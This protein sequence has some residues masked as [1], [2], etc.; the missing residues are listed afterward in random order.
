[1]A[2]LLAAVVAYT[3]SFSVV[4]QGLRGVGASPE[5]AASGLLAL[6][7]VMGLCSIV[8]SWRT[9]MPVSIA[10]S[11]PGAAFLAISGVPEGGFAAAVGA[12]VI[13]GVLLVISGALRPVARLIGKVPRSLAS[14]MLAGILFD[15][16]LAPVRAFAEM[17]WQGALIALTFIAVGLWKRLFAVP[18]TALVTIGL[19]VAAMPADFSFAN[20]LGTQPVFVMPEFRFSAM[21]GIAVPLFIITMA[22]QNVPGFAILK[23]NGYEPA[24]APIF[25]ATG[26]AT[27]VSAP[28]GA[29]VF[30]LA[31]ITAALC[32]GEEAG[33]N[34]RLRYLSGI[35]SGL[36]YIVFGLSAGLIVAFAELSPV[37]ISAIAGLALLGAFA[38]SVHGAMEN[39]EE[40]EAAAIAFIVTA[41]GIS[42]LGV[43][44]AFWGLVVGA[45]IMTVQHLLK[46]A[47]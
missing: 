28:F 33:P 16:C 2:G 23:L 38:A 11:T 46:K 29:S 34:R 31:A 18:V 43:S 6:S 20:A 41:S 35:S 14:A 12:F 19:V 4:V 21:I 15:L 45:G 32:A 24:P 37:L 13:T 27:M 47:R 3:S 1:M 44:A 7:V 8:F 39:L 5:Q 25:T 22:S 26:I 36:A 42:F 9:R 10:W 30:N 40:R 17:P